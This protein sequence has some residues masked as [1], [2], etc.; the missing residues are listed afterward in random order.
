[1]EHADEVSYLLIQVKTSLVGLETPITF[2]SNT[3]DL[4]YPRI[5]EREKRRKMEKMKK[6]EDPREQVM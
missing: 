6:I 3:Q 2:Y 5:K 1:M 4:K